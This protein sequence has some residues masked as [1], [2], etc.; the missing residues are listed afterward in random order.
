[1]LSIYPRGEIFHI[2]YSQGAVHLVRGSLGT[3]HKDVALRYQHKLEIAIAEGA[4]SSEWLNLS[5]T[6]FPPKTLGRF[7]AFFGVKSSTTWKQFRELFEAY[8]K[9]QASAG[10]IIAAT[11]EDYVG[12]LDCFGNFL[13]EQDISRI[14]DLDKTKIE[15]FKAQRFQQMSKSKRFTNGTSLELEIVRLH[16]AFAYAVGSG[17]IQKNPIKVNRKRFDETSDADPYTGDELKALRL[18]CR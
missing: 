15:E 14:T 18:T 12:V 1:M 16:H 4:Q 7:A 10:E 13:Q 9:R 11:V 17:V 5:R 2:D 3:K 6:N 8:K